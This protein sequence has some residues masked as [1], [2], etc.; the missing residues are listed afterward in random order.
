MKKFYTFILFFLLVKISSAQITFQK[1]YGEIAGDNG[2]SVQQTSDGGYIITGFTTGRNTYLIKTDATGDTLWTKIFGG[3][4]EAKGVQQTTDGGYIICGATYDF[5]AGDYDFYLIKTDA[6]GDTLWTKTYGG[7]GDDE[8]TSV[9]QTADGGYIITGETGEINGFDVYLIKTDAI[10]D[11]SW[12][13]TFGGTNTDFARCVQQTTD[14]GFIITGITSSF[15]SGAGDVYLIYIGDTVWTKTYG[16]AGNEQGFSVQ[17]TTDGGY[18]IVGNTRSFGAGQEDAYLIKTDAI[19]DTL[20]TKTFGGAGYDGGYSVQQTTDGGYIIVGYTSSFGAGNYDVYL[21]KTNAIGN[22]LWTKTFGGTGHEEG[23]SV[24]QTT[25]GGHIIACMTG[26]F[27]AGGDVYLI[28]TDSLGNSGCN[29]TNPATII[30]TPATIVTNPA[31]IVSSNYTVVTSPAF[32]I[33]SG[34][35]VGTLCLTVGTDEISNQQST[36][37]IYPNP[38]FNEIRINST[39]ENGEVVLYDVTGKK[40][41]RQT[42]SEAETKLNTTK[43]ATGF[44]ILHYIE[45]NHMQNIKL[46]KM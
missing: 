35:I 30:N 43:I 2:S 46:T 14:G 23:F 17:Q 33:G 13:K 20:W 26:S 41:L 39:K 5:G 10:G 32:T 7:T 3:T 28:K 8:P 1:T 18:V 12:T 25:D 37:S 31:S 40:I 22:A 42:T 24:Q 15:G 34:G 29:Q 21:I 11:T 9:Q 38:F 36:I 45:G 44:Y 27:G 6:I 19:G 16:G 4:D